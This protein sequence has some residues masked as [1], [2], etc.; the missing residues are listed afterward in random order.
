M[1]IHGTTYSIPTSISGTASAEPVVVVDGR[2][3]TLPVSEGLGAAV[4]SGLQGGSLSGSRTVGGSV[5]TATTSLGSAGT[6]VQGSAP[7][8]VST[9]GARKQMNVF[10]NAVAVAVVVGAIGMVVT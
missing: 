10:G 5:V 9:G 4:I 3:S 2:T 7:A 6:S 8:V 1:T